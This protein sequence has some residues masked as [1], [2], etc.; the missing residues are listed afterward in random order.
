MDGEHVSVDAG[1]IEAALVDQF[2]D[3]RPDLGPQAPAR[4]GVT[5]VASHHVDDQASAGHELVGPQLEVAGPVGVGLVGH[6]HGVVPDEF[7]EEQRRPGA[8][9]PVAATAERRS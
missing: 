3:H 5:L 2:L 6:R 9:G 4:G 1:G 8:G 7:V